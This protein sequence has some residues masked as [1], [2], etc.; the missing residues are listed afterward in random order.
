MNSVKSVLGSYLGHLGGYLVAA[1]SIVS[2][3]DPK[4]V[5]PQYSFL[6][7]VA[8][9]VVIAS[10]HSY[11]A[12][13]NSIITAGA[14]AVASAIAQT[15]AKLMISAMLLGVVASASLGLTA[16]A[17]A[18][19]ASERG[20]VV[21][22]DVATGLALSEGG[23]VSDLAVLKARAVEYKAI[24]MK[25]KAVNDA[26]TATLATLAAALQPEIAKLPPADQLAA[27]A[28]IAA[29]TPYLQSQIPGNAD[30]QNI[31]TTVDLILSNVILA[32]EAYGA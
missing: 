4:L 9:A 5:P 16:C 18:P 24:A 17:T 11:Q 1:A 6:T 14:N 15:P 13:A 28:L 31:Q 21:A 25:V 22:V 30:V 12:G 26:G 32:C 3:L 10:H 27:Q 7:A 19:T 29:L 2:G 23:K 8:G 20:I